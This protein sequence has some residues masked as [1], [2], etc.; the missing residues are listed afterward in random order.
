MPNKHNRARNPNQPPNNNRRLIGGFLTLGAVGVAASLL[1]AN[2]L[3]SS[4]DNNESSD[5]GNGGNTPAT[6]SPNPGTSSPEAPR[7][8]PTETPSPTPSETKPSAAPS[9]SQAPI[10]MRSD[11]LMDKRH[12]AADRYATCGFTFTN[13][14]DSSSKSELSFSF[15]SRYQRNTDSF[16]LR[17]Q[18]QSKSLKWDTPQVILAKFD[19]Q[20]KID[21]DSV[22]N[23]AEES[24]EGSPDIR[25][26]M[27][28]P[29]SQPKK[30]TTYG[31]FIKNEAYTPYQDQDYTM[32]T[33]AAT[34]CGSIAFEGSDGWRESDVDPLPPDNSVVMYDYPIS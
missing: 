1:G 3:I 4:C 5:L 15:A 16:E 23:T 22:I 12:T 31:V 34:F 28:Y 7:T 30:G 6:A 26:A 32:A 8:S 9:P 10:D 11:P 17:E 2:M 20:G 29:P 27:V 25:G 18:G 21:N 33:I 14:G 24:F 13:A 19:N